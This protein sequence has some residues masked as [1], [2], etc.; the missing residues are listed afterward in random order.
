MGRI[1]VVE[2]EVSGHRLEYY[3][4]IYMAATKD[5]CNQY[6][7]VFSADYR[8][9][10]FRFDW[11]QTENIKIVI[12]SEQQTMSLR[13][14]IVKL[15]WKRSVFLI[16]LIR[17]YQPNK[18]FLLEVI[19]YLPY[20]PVFLAFAHHH[21][22][23]NGI[24][25]LVYTYRWKREGYVRRVL[26][27]VKFGLMAKSNCFKNIYVINDTSAVAYLNHLYKTNHFKYAPDPIVPIKNVMSVNIRKIYQISESQILLVQYGGLSRIKGTI[28]ILKALLLLA[29]QQ[30]S[31]FAIILAG[32]VDASCRTEIYDL[33]K[34]LKSTMNITLKDEFC[35]Y[36]FIGALCK[37]ANYVMLPYLKN[38]GSSGCLGIAAQ[39][40]IPVISTNKNLLGKLIRRNKLGIAL[41]DVSAKGLS[42]ILMKLPQ[43]YYIDNSLYIKKNSVEA[44]Q[45]TI[46]NH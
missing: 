42:Q 20:V 36:K 6:I 10:Q 22:E 21:I 7:F 12:L 43:Q 38:E 45:S 29:P 31:R 18:I 40:N 28:E 41:D 27:V 13:G 26:D 5:I 39:F 25:F 16:K 9:Q 19:F 8:K 30:R 15:T 4:H 23:I 11:P 2:P 32:K 46:F 35:T 37:V 34:R 24:V 3:H 33:I 44:F 14:N 17:Q 1:L